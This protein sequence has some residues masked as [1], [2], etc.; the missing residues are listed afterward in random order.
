ME[1]PTSMSTQSP[2]Y[3]YWAE[4][5]A[6]LTEEFI[7]IHSGSSNGNDLNLVYRE[8]LNAMSDFRKDVRDARDASFLPLKESVKR[9]Y[10]LAIENGLDPGSVI[11]R[12][13]AERADEWSLHC[14]ED[15]EV[16][17]DIRAW[18]NHEAAIDY[19]A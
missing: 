10:E 9:A 5:F 13:I 14:S 4:K 18:L 6:S 3:K 12:T 2:D 1:K 7:W 19:E 11:L 8:A 17:D 15:R 16:T